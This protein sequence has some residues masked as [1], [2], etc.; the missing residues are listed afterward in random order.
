MC[1]RITIGLAD[2]A[3]ADAAKEFGTYTICPPETFVNNHWSVEKYMP[4]SIG[5]TLCEFL[6]KTH[7]VICDYVLST[8]QKQIYKQHYQNDWMIKQ[9]L[10][11]IFKTKMHMGEKT[12]I[13]FSKYENFPKELEVL[14]H[15]MLSINMH[16]RKTLKELYN[17]PIFKQYRAAEKAEQYMGIIAQLHCNVVQKALL[18][19]NQLTTVY[20][21]MRAKLINHI[22]DVY[23]SF[24]KLNLFLQAVHIFDKYCSV[25]VIDLSKIY[26][27]GIA[28]A[29]VAQ[30]IEK[31]LPIPLS[32]FVATLGW[33]SPMAVSVGCITNI[34]E[35]ILFCCSQMMYS[36][37]FDVQIAKTGEKIN[38][39]TILDIMKK[40]L[41]PYNNN[42][43]VKEYVSRK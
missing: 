23:C 12:L 4:W 10:G 33:L 35:D 36:Q 24:N 19:S 9:I 1:A 6:F 43:L 20:S 26:N 21:Q 18:H 5:V 28:A 15:S 16:E 38:M 40:T 37:T 3:A 7:S 27:V 31:S 39:V 32:T 2:S 30:Y 34:V 14:L 42:M 25:K 11:Q 13:D 22:F 17:L 8:E 29:Y 41:P